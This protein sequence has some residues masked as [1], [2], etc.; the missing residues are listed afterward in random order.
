MERDTE[1]TKVI[2]CPVCGACPEI[3]FDGEGVL[4]GEEGNRVKLKK[5]EWNDLV[6]K[7]KKGE[8]GEI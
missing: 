8:L 7:I 2:L 4:I 3:V 6:L 1:K 5:Q